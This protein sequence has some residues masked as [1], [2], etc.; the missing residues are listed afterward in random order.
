MKDLD[1]ILLSTSYAGSIEY[2]ARI[3]QHEHIIIEKEENYLKQTFRNRTLIAA[4]NGLF[5]LIIP[6]IRK[7]GNHTKIK[8]VEISYSEKWQKLHWRTIVSAYSNAPYFLYYQ[9]D[10]I[11]FYENQHSFL[12]DFN[13]Q[14]LEVILNLLEIRK[15][16]TFTTSYKSDQG[17]SILDLRNSI[18]P[19]IKSNVSFPQYIQVFEQK[20]GF[21]PN[22]GIFDLL[23][24]EGP[25]TFEYLNKIQLGN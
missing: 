8:D 14:L 15:D 5:P 19:K 23:F 24:N 20:Y 13:S 21:L 6:V 2:F 4:A 1:S 16:F 17:A 22:L 25:N 9:D 7:N 12:L 10:L 11:P 18:S 3:V